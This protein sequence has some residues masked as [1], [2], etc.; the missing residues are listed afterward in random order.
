MRVWARTERAGT[1]V[2]KYGLAEAALDQTSAVATTT[3]EHDYTGWV[4][5][6]KLKAGTTYYYQVYVNDLPSGPAGRFLT[7]PD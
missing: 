6:E 5:L 2:V 7:L 4:S 1:F 3:L